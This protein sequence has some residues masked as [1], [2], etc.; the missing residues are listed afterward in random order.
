MKKEIGILLLVSTVLLSAC[1]TD[2]NGGDKQEESS[3]SSNPVITQ[4]QQEGKATESEQKT[5]DSDSW[6]SENNEVKVTPV[7]K[8]KYGTTEVVSVEVN[9]VKKEFNW[10]VAEEPRVFYADVTSDDK[11]EVVIINNIGRGT[12]TS[13][14]EL[15]VLNSEDLSEI[16]VP[17]YEEVV[18]EHIESHVTKNK[19]GKLA[20]KVKAQGEDY[21]FSYDVDPGLEVQ[22]KL[23][24]GGT[25][26]YIFENG[27]IA[28][29]IGG[30]IGTSP[31]YV[32]NFHI[33]Y[34]FDSV[35]NAFIVDQIKVEPFKS[36][37]S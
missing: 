22:D 1:G 36:N 7:K 23:L 24:F 19:D 10:Q 14:D 30:S 2:N 21:E 27:K 13:I 12:D 34:K 37:K 33:T 4:P 25:V 18:A 16:K 20:I 9:G 26:T 29:D 11:P 31:I 28:S 17:N 32:S 15:H 6:S 35:K 8:D 5:K 3:T